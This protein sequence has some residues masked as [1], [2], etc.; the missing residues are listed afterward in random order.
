MY[1]DIIFGRLTEVDREIM[2]KSIAIINRADPS[3][4]NYMRYHIQ[5]CNIELGE[6]YKKAKELASILLGNCEQAL[7]EPPRCKDVTFP[8]APST[9]ISEKGD[10]QYSEV[11][12]P[13]VRKLESYVKEMAAGSKV[14]YRLNM[15]KVQQDIANLYE[16]VKQQPNMSAAGKDH[17][18]SLYDEVLKSFNAGADAGCTTKNRRSSSSFVSPIVEQ[19]TTVSDNSLP[20]LHLKRNLTGDWSYSKQLTCVYLDILTEIATSGSSFEGT[21]ALLTGCGRGSIGAEVLKGLLSGGCKVVV[22]TSSY[23]RKTVEYYQQIYQV[24]G[25]RGSKLVVVPFNQAS[26]QDCDALVDYIY[27]PQGLNLD[28]DYVVPFAAISENGRE[29]DSIDDTSELAHRLMLTN[30]IRLIGSIKT[31]KQSLGV[32]TRPTQIVLPQSPNHGL[33]GGDGLYAESKI[34]LEPLFNKWK[35]ESW[36]QYISLVGAVIG[37]TRGTGLMNSTN[38]LAEGVEKHGVRTFSAKEMGFNILGLMHPILAGINSVEPLWADLSGGML[39]LPQLNQIME[40]LRKEITQ[41]AEVTASMR[42][43]QDLDKQVVHGVHP[44]VASNVQLRANF[45]FEFPKLSGFAQLQEKLKLRN[46]SKYSDFSLRN[47]IDLD[48]SVVIV[49]FAEVGPWGSSRTRWEMEA[50]GKFSITGCLELARIMGY[51]KFFNG[52]LKDG[53]QYIGWVETSTGQPI[54]D[55]QVKEKYEQE[56]LEHTG[57]RLIGIISLM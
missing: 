49:G 52:R 5:S 11:N 22:T 15:E 44:I 21:N 25:S 13:G 12:R 47:M 4:L 2:A 33:F 23:S 57:I 40:D 6:S 55:A 20:F 34:G 17:I 42:K 54:T 1:F 8:T 41:K 3:L 36:S 26:R 51:V 29:V 9:S 37:W 39:L 16:M 48:Q 10:I 31:K 35:S 46:K 38:I 19:P 14:A 18:K 43:E 27:S 32:K 30:L 45:T 56:I 24:Y 50:V 53:K 28:L 7:S